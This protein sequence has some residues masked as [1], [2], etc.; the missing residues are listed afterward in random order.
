MPANMKRGNTPNFT[1]LPEPGRTAMKTATLKKLAACGTLFTYMMAF[2][3]PPAQ[4]APGPLA[5]VPLF[6]SSPVQPNVMLLIDN[7][8]SMDNIVWATGYD[9]SVTYPDWGRGGGGT[10]DWSSADG[11]KSRS[12]IDRGPC[13]A[14]WQ[15]G[16]NGTT[17]KC[18]KL[19]DPAGG[20]NTRYTGNYLN[21]LFNTY[22][23]GTDLTPSTSPIPRDTRIN[24]ARNV[25]TNIVTTVPG[26]R[27]GIASFNPSRTDQGGIIRAACGS[28]TPTLT[29]AISSLTAATWTPLGE[30]LYEITR[31][32]RGMTSYYNSGT[33]YTSPIQYRCQKNF[34]I[35]ITDGL[36]TYDSDFPTNDADDLADTTRSLPN[37]DGKTGTPTTTSAMYPNFPKYSDGFGGSIAA[38]GSTLL[39]DDL[40]KFGYDIDLRKSPLTDLT[41]TS[42]DDKDFKKQNL[43]TYTIG[44][45]VDNQM[46]EDAAEY[47]Q[48]QYFTAT[49]AASLT[50]A[51]QKVVA[52]ISS[53]VGSAAAVAF[54]TSTLNTNSNVY[55]ASFNPAGWS[56]DLASYDL[57]ATNGNIAAT[58]T[59]KASAKLDA[60]SSRTILT[61]DGTKG[62]P[63]Q[64]SK[65]SASQQADLN[66]GPSTADGKG[67]DRVAYLRGD[68]SNE[69]TGLSFRTRASVLGDIV[70]STPVY[71]GASGLTYPTGGGFSGY[72]T[73]KS[74]P[75]YAGR[76]N[77]IYVGANDGM[78]H[79]FDDATGEEILAYIPN[80]L[81]SAGATA[82]LHYLTNPGYSHRYYVD[83]SPTIAD[84]KVSGLGWR[85]VLIGS[86]AAGGRGLFAL[87]VTDPSKFSEGGSNP[88]DVVMWEF[89]PAN[90][91]A[92]GNDLG[93][94]FSKPVI[95][96]MNTGEWVAIFGNGYN[97]TGTGTAKLF[98]AKLDGGL[99]GTWTE[100]TD[101]IKIDTGAGGGGPAAN[102]LTTPTI[103]DLD[104]DGVVDRI[105]AGDLQGNMWAFD[106][107]A[108]S[109]GSWDV[110][111]KPGGTK[112]ALFTARNA[113]GATQAITTQPAVVKMP[114][115]SDTTAN[116]PNLLVMFGTGQYLVNSDQTSTG[117]QT[118]YG[119]WD[120]GTLPGSPS[121][122]IKRADLTAQ[123]FLT[124]VE[125]GYRVLSDNTVDYNI[126][127]GWYIDLDKSTAATGERVVTNA[128]VKGDY[129]FFNSMI[130]STAACSFGG[131]SWL[132]SAKLAN[133]GNPAKPVFDKNGAGGVTSADTVTVGTMNMAAAGHSIGA[134][135]ADSVFL[136]DQQYTSHS[137]DGT[138]V[139]VSKMLTDTNTA[140]RTGRLSW[141]ELSR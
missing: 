61:Y 5:D 3:V 70:H 136:G 99:D 96:L 42:F 6:L 107:S 89:T 83:G 108:T 75:A 93:Y 49:D 139:P 79:G 132:M 30:A 34:V 104:R 119:V 101:Y 127:Y 84:A 123:T 45:S 88:R 58:A 112:K 124:G 134:V 110:A 53:R 106:V 24:V 54:N 128:V 63:F 31:Y 73:F 98:I 7:S 114:G 66:M 117:T 95:A 90:S 115:I 129:V 71:V 91:G 62:I 19:P 32:F 48:G 50:D 18:L 72:D 1:K 2:V 8:G 37:W 85:T 138:G 35:V 14:D 130:P 87:D 133:G 122:S 137:G 80:S 27:F 33:S 64:W 140:R 43:N 36:P 131:T 25:A 68:R 67:P 74:S 23:N 116:S 17:T 12:S 38:E 126:K 141:M 135:A 125:A 82:G 47:G 105:Y 113:A 59:W 65:L 44:F 111:H 94:T 9:N 4:A 41:G 77:V 92:S 60:Q 102:G 29:S 21:Y 20:G 121:D 78:L 40:A 46:L 81:F 120:R 16:N 57:D 100:G 26:M 56:G 13:S 103:V 51:L 22:A 28:S 10:R 86:L 109:W 15:R 55:Q 97:D 69:G 39:M 11:N 118:F 76:K 52:N